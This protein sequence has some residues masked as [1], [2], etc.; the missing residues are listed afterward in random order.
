[1][2]SNIYFMH[3]YYIYY[4]AEFAQEI[5]NK[6]RDKTLWKFISAYQ[7]KLL[8]SHVSIKTTRAFHLCECVV[9]LPNKKGC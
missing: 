7:K 4:I 5:V 3:I 9:H 2:E 1:M 6:I 8:L